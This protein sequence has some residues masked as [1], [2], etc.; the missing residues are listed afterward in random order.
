MNC[1]D[2]ITEVYIYLDGEATL[3]KRTRVKVHLRRCDGCSDAFQFERHIIT[4]VEKS[5][6]SDEI[7]PELFGRLQAL[8]RQEAN[9]QGSGAS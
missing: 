9:E 5:C 1:D 2:A 7:P 3:I 6:K 4:M 8:I